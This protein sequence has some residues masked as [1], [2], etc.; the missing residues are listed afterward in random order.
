MKDYNKYSATCPEEIELVKFKEGTLPEEDKKLLTEHLLVCD[1]CLMRLQFMPWDTVEEMKASLAEE[2]P[3]VEETVIP[4]SLMKAFELQ[5]KIQSAKPKVNPIPFNEFPKGK[6]KAG[7]IW[8]TKH[9]NIVFP[10]P[11]GEEFY[12][13][14]DL[15]SVPHLVVITNPS[16]EE[17]DNLGKKYHV[18][19]AV[20][21]D[22]NIHFATEGDIVVSEDESPLGYPF[23][24][25]AWNQQQMLQ[26]NLD[27]WLGEINI[28][29]QSFFSSVKTQVSNFID[30]LVDLG[31]KEV[32][33]A[34]YAFIGLIEKGIY[35]DPIM[36]YRAREFENTVY[37]SDP[38]DA[39][40]E[41][42]IM[43]FESEANES[44]VWEQAKTK[45]FE[46]S[47]IFSL[48]FVASDSNESSGRVEREEF[49]GGRLLL[50]AE[51]NS[52][53]EGEII[54]KTSDSEFANK[55][56]FLVEPVKMLVLLSDEITVPNR[57]VAI[58]KIGKQYE[59]ENVEP[60]E[61]LI[62]FQKLSE[63]FENGEITE[64]IIRNSVSHI[65]TESGLK[66]WR[67]AA[68]SEEMNDRLR[69]IIL[70]AIG[71]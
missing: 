19:K 61:E 27:S 2:K 31:R 43:V 58:L 20:T 7:Q 10:S 25:Q 30:Y 40:R 71:N 33:G 60:V 17:I 28:N 41:P 9:N 44:D 45:I 59:N 64:E 16:Y 12:S 68:L 26:E 18:I 37:L 32:T 8:R 70:K 23:M 54:F 36:R 57:Q 62:N 38:V 11:E 24:I 3:K 35:S 50:E 66:A 55:F 65:A 22:N 4:E 15:G 13:V 29:P 6:L 69:E 39:L 51:L 34:S 63:K 46:L 14:S 5:H 49:F 53:G 56:F 42:L 48:A 52:K 21:I 1:Y 47:R 67:K